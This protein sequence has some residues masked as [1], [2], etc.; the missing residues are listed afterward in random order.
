MAAET[1]PITGAG[2]L[3]RELI[4][5]ERRAP[6]LFRRPSITDRLY[7]I[8]A[9]ARRGDAELRV[10]P[11]GAFGEA[12]RVYDNDEPYQQRQGAAAPSPMTATEVNAVRDSCAMQVSYER[13]VQWVTL[14]AT[15]LHGLLEG[16]GREQIVLDELQQIA[17]AAPAWSESRT[18]QLTGVVAAFSAQVQ[19]L[20]ARV[21][22]AVGRRD[23]AQRLMDKLLDEIR[24]YRT[25][26]RELL[27]SRELG[28]RALARLH[29]LERRH[30]AVRE[31]TPVGAARSD[32]AG[33]VNGSGGL[34]SNARRS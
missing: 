5:I 13:L 29:H 4:D 30:G 12:V 17:A 15:R 20:T 14:H 10:E 18:G 24:E 21:K 22:D 8:V 11:R 28:D 27:M 34:A 1:E 7:H 3:L 33:R 32:V 16:Y 26:S 9:Q 31:Q 2:E 6:Q 23:D 25:A 19:E